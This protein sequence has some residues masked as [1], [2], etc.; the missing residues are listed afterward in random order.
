MLLP[1]TIPATATRSRTSTS[2]S[3]SP[4]ITTSAVTAIRRPCHSSEIRRAEVHDAVVIISSTNAATVAGTARIPFSSRA[5]TLSCTAAR[6]TT[7]IG[8]QPSPIRA[9]RARATVSP[10]IVSS[11]AANPAYDAIPCTS[12]VLRSPT[13]T[14]AH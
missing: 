4:R 8:N 10:V 12:P 6:T 1:I 14:R 9:H 13:V 5:T 11:P 7:T 2:T 3:R